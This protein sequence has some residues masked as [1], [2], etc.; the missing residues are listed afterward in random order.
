MTRLDDV[1]VSGI[2]GKEAGCECV[3]LF[4]AGGGGDLGGL[5]SGLLSGLCGLM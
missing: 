2:V 4:L 1:G 5:L 3:V